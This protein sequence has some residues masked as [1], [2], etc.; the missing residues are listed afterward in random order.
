VAAAPELQRADKLPPDMPETL[1]SL[2]KA[3][4]L[5]RLYRKQGKTAQA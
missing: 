1:S 2:G 3:A 5:A 4:S